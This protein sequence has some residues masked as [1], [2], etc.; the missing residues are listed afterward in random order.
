MPVRKR[1][2]SLTASLL[3][4]FL[5]A[6]AP[7]AL[8]DAVKST[9]YYN[10]HYASWESM[11][12]AMQPYVDAAFTAARDVLG[13]DNAG[14]A[15]IDVYF[16]SDAKNNADGY[17]YTGQNV[18]Y[19]NLARFSATSADDAK[20]LDSILSHETSHLLFNHKTGGYDSASS[21]YDEA[22]A[23]YV[24]NVAYPY[25][26]Q[27]SKSEIGASLSYYS[28]K[29]ATKSGWFETGL[30][31]SEGNDTS[32]DWWQ[33]NAIGYYLNSL[34]GWQGIQKTL[35]YLASSKDLE[36]SLIAAYG[37]PS[38]QF[39]TSTGSRVNTLYSDYYHY[40]FGHY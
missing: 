26:P 12:N 20:S 7:A 8:A 4:L 3:C 22:L 15:K 21:W 29:G 40:Y 23:Y 2:A 13:Y 36:W 28:H 34:G 11:A 17:Y 25:G 9:T 24:G 5:V 35:M 31:Y 37:E 30:R 14:Y 19:L 18:L 6:L 32:L 1:F 38:G 27:Y 39:G 33:L 10:L 16:T